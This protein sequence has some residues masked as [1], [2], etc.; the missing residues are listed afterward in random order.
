MKILLVQTSFLGD[1]ILSTP[2]IAAI[3]K[4]YPDSE[5]WMMITPLSADLVSANP[6][7]K[8]V[9]TY[10]KKKSDRGIKGIIRKASELEKH[11]FDVAYSLHRSYRT[12]LLLFLTGI[13]KRVGFSQGSLSFLYSR[14]V[15]RDTTSHD[16]IR[17]LSLLSQEPLFLNS[18]KNSEDFFDAEMQLFSKDQKLTERKFP[19]IFSD[20]KEFAI[21]I[22][23]SA[24]KTKRWKWQG[25]KEVAEDLISKGKRVVIF[26]SGAE[27]EI[28][29]KVAEGLS[30]INL[31]GMST[32]SES[33]AIMKKASL[34]VCN[35]SMS[36][37]MASALKVPNVS[38]FCATSPA[39]G[40]GP[41]RNK[42]AVVE[43]QGLSCKPCRRH[44][45]NKCPTG[46]EACM[47]DLG[48]DKIILEIDK[49]I[50]ISKN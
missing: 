5:L 34:V 12:A 8:G 18:G 31:A 4:L 38:V 20:S 26:G 33:I 16:V 14:T 29:Q 27:K 28:C 35:D 36:L 10:D 23:G 2:V 6:S 32:I 1:T 19:E 13:P 25:F 42:A 44:G 46:T 17:N 45:S 9:I 39:F 15:L 41:W 22:P 11:K 24:W 21:L 37:H 43:M 47:N 30:C 40:F 50:Q 3:K 48:S 7:L 49:L